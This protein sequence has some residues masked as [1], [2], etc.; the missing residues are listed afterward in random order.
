[1]ADYIKS[2]RKFVGHTPI[3]LNTVTGIVMDHGRS[4]LQERD[5]GGWCLPGGYLEYGKSYSEACKR[6]LLEDTRLNVEVIRPLGMF[7]KYFMEYSNGSKLQNHR[8]VIFD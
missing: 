5:G 1:M 4:L 3:I 2:I 8:Y 7:D 6:E